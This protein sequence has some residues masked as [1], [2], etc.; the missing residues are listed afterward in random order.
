L[1]KLVAPNPSVMTGPGTNTYLLGTDE[2]VVI[3]PGPV[4]EGHLARILAAGGGVISTVL[5]THHHNDHAPLARAVA[6]AAGAQL[7]GFGLAG[8]FEPDRR[9]RD[10]ERLS[11]GGFEILVLHTPGHASDHCCFLVTEE[12]VTEGWERPLLFS[13]DHVMSGST[14]VIAP[15]DGDMTAYVAS[16]GHLIST[17]DD[18]AIAPGHGD[19]IADGPAKLAAYLEHRLDREQMVL[20]ALGRG[21]A[22]P[23]ELV[24]LIYTRLSPALV[25]PAAASVWA[26]LRR[27]F[28]L[29]LAICQDVDDPSARW[30]AV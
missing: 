21:P 24:P 7:L 27:L 5:V 13:G 19:I 14:V 18:V 29:G 17:L 15:P 26:H 22:S 6:S 23:A 4:D 20:R 11:V 12:I 30:Q 3:D 10:G 25:A 28:E 16:L 9:L 2:I 8:R 1:V